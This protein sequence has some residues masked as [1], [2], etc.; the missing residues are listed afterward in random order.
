MEAS[1]KIL[2]HEYKYIIS[3]RQADLLIFRL[4]SI[5]KNDIHSGENNKYTIRSLYLDDMNERLM[6]ESINGISSRSKYRFRLYNANTK[7]INLERKRTIKDLKNK[8]KVSVDEA[9]VKEFI[10]RKELKGNDEIIA[11]IKANG[12]FPKSIIEYKR[13]AFVNRVGNV[14]ITFDSDIMVDD[15]VDEFLNK[16][17]KGMPVLPI[18]RTILEVKYDSILP[19]YITEVLNT[20]SLQR[21]SYSK[22]VMGRN[23]MNNNGR[24]E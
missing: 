22:Y 6:H 5:M 13:V 9:D 20:E 17:I 11:E 23:L 1:D 18:D 7:L 3:N 15:R 10:N 16:K 21:T 4:Q 12:Y 8:I 24:L 2:R 14:R 19:G